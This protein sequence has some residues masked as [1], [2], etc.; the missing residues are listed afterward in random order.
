MSDA[1]GGGNAI[2]EK[3][4]KK[5]N[6]HT[7]V[8][9]RKHV[10][11][12]ISNY[13]TVDSNKDMT[14]RS[15]QMSNKVAVPLLLDLGKHASTEKAAEPRRANPDK[16]R[17]GELAV[18]WKGLNLDLVLVCVDDDIRRKPEVEVVHR[19]DGHRHVWWPPE[20][21]ANP[22]GDG[23]HLDGRKRHLDRQVT[24]GVAMQQVEELADLLV[25]R[26]NALP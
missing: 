18:A 20:F 10:L 11:L 15:A 16:E 22:P 2:I 24:K 4:Q 9:Q 6:T 5:N 19:L 23:S 12:L 3:K 7:H 8:A 21:R 17:P 13:Q 1:H 14:V 26:T 25:S